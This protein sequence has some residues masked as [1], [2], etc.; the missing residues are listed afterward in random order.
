MKT[1]SPCLN[2]D[3]RQINCH[4]K[5]KAYKKYRREN[6]KFNRFIGTQKKKDSLGRRDEDE[7]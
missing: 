3:K 2:C 6:S 5:C 4:A 7:V 1:N